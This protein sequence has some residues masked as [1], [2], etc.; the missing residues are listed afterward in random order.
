MSTDR[1]AIVPLALFSLALVGQGLY[2]D[3]TKPTKPLAENI[4]LLDATGQIHSLATISK[5]KQARVFV[6][7]TGECPISRSYFP[8]LG[9]LDEKWNT[10]DSPV[11][12]QAVWADVTDSPAEI[13]K[14]A[15]EFSIDLPIL[16]DRDG[17]LG[18]RFGTKIVPEAF[19]LDSEGQLVY[20]G[21]IDDKYREIGRK[22]PEA[23]ENT[24]E[25]AVA[26]VVAGQPVNSAEV[27]AIGC[28]YE[29][30]GPL[31]DEVADI[32]YTRDVAPIL[33]ANCVQC[34]REGEV[35][36]FPL[37]TYEDAAK[38]ARQIARVCDSR[39]MPPWKVAERH[40]EFEGQR[41]LTDKQIAT[42]KQWAATNRAKG[43]LAE[44][45]EL[46][47][48]PEGWYLGEPD[49]IVEM[50]V[51]FEVPADGPDLYQNFVIP[52]DIPEDKYVATVEFK[53]GAASVV[54]H[55]LLYLD[56]NGAARK[57]DEKTPEPGYGTFGG[58]GFLP[59]GS[60][61]GWSPGKMPRKLPEG[62]GRLLGKGSDLVMQIHYHPSG[63]VEKDRSKVGIYFVDKPKQEAFALW[64]SS[65]L[66]DIPPGENDYKLRAAYTL[67]EDVTML[68]IIPHMHLLGQTMN[69]VAELPDGSTRDLLHMPQW[70]FNWQDEY[71]YAEPFELPKGTKIVSY[72]T[73]DNSEDN[74]SNPSSPP[75]R[76][77]WGEGTNDEMLYCFFLVTTEDKDAI[78]PMVVDRL[79]REG[80]DRAAARLRLKMAYPSGKLK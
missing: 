60:I 67:T 30:Y 15:Q 65:F 43:D 5:K 40:G 22:R 34:H 26:A 39:L 69:V 64:T 28:Y 4:S 10:P 54:H 63:K 37:V 72:A 20:R 53:P 78:Q 19:V 74:P 58:P 61:G 49:L 52:I 31:K 62:L 55:S 6:F 71:V 56:K 76:V 35:G 1:I 59:T 45:P 42:L 38:R 46:P 68:S 27:A 66:H 14:F 73:Y 44:M 29:S 11:S 17:E 79:T 7:V 47:K 12:L 77:T 21:R 24:L 50:P 13:R 36:P 3:E 18:Q 75:E 23:T 25:E 48:F 16:V 32:T 9:R 2:A 70:D 57:L 8:L 80:I 33:F 51:E 41:T